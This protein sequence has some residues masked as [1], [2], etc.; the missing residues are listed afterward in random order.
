MN[1]KSKKLITV[2]VVPVVIIAAVAGYYLY[3]VEEPIRVDEGYGELTIGPV[4]NFDPVSGWAGRCLRHKNVTGVTTVNSVSQLSLRVEPLARWLDGRPFPSE[5]TFRSNF[6]VRGAFEGDLNIESLRIEVT[7]TQSNETSSVQFWIQDIE[8][9]GGELWPEKEFSA[10]QSFPNPDDSAFIGF[11]LYSNE[12]VASGSMMWLSR[13]IEENFTLQFQA[14]V[15][16]N[17]SERVVSTVVLYIEG[18]D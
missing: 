8:I 12:F 5:Q 7:E 14:I 11:D 18:C 9:D 15:K 17:F 13:S 3:P 2:F 10:G 4:N 16:G 6:Q 1:L